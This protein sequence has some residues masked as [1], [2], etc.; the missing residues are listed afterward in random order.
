[1]PELL[2]ILAGYVPQVM[3]NHLI[4]HP[5]PLVT[6]SAERFPAAVLFADIS[7]FTALA[8]RLTQQ[9]SAGIEKLSN[10]LNTYFSQLIELIMAHG[11]EIF[12]FAGD[13]PIALWPVAQPRNHHLIRNRGDENLS[14]ATCRAVQCGLALQSIFN[15]YKVAEGL[16]LS[17]RVGIGAGE[18][19]MASVGGVR[20]RWE[21]LVAGEPITQMCHAERQAHPGEVVL[22]SEAWKLIQDQCSG[23]QLPEGGVLI[24][25]LREPLPLRPLSPINPPPGFEVILRSYIPAAILT[26]LDAGQTEWLAELRRITVLFFNVMG[27]DYTSPYILDRLQTVMQ[28]LQTVLYRYEGSVNQFLVDDK[29]TILVAALGLPPLAHEDDAVRGVQ[30][31]LGMQAELQQ[32]GL[33]SAAGIA[34]GRVFCGERGSLIRREYGM[35]GDVVNLAARL[36]QVVTEDLSIGQRILCDAATYQAARMRLAFKTLP[37]ITVKGK[38]EPIAVYSPY[39]QIKITPKSQTKMVGRITER[40]FLLERLRALREGHGSIVIIEGEAG[41]GKSR[42]IQ[43]L[44]QQAQELGIASLMGVGDAVEKSIPYHAWHPIFNQLFNLDHLTDDLET[45]RKQILAQLQVDPEWL[46]WAPLLNSI[47]SLDLPE[48]EITSQMSAQVRAENTRNLLLR[49]IEKAADR[50]PMMVI[51]E[52]AHWLDSASW[53]L[54]LSLGR[55][56]HHLL[57]IISTRPMMDP[58]LAEYH[59]FLATQPGRWGSKIHRL[60]LG[61]LLPEETV[62]M[63]T[64]RLG[65]TALPE[66]VAKLIQEKAEGH[67]LFSEELAYAL[68][69]AGLILISHG[70]CYIS[71][72]AGDFSTLNFSDTLQGL[73]IGR[74]DRLTAQQQL[75]LKV[76]SV[77]GRVF[78]SR[79]LQDIYPIESDKAQLVYYLDALEKLNIILPET[80]GSDLTYKFKH[81]MTQEVAYNLMLFSQRRGLHRAVARWYEGVYAQDLTPFYPLLAYHWSKAEEESKAIHYLEKAGEQA[82]RIGAYREALTFFSEALKQDIREDR[83]RDK[84]TVALSTQRPIAKSQLRWARWE[85]QM[86][87]ICLELGQLP[88]SRDHLER[89]LALLGRSVPATRRKLLLSLA[90]QVL[91][92]FWPG[93]PITQ[94]SDG[95]KIEKI[96][97]EE[98]R[99]ILLEAVRAYIQLGKVYYFSNE[100]SAVIHATLYTLHLASRLGPSPELAQSYANMCVGMGFI[101]LYS[102]A[103]VYLRRAQEAA[104]NL[105]ELPT[106]AYVLIITSVYRLGIG[107][108]AEAQEALNQAIEICD[109]LGNRQQWAESLILLEQIAYYQGVFARGEKLAVDLYTRACR[110]SNFLHQAWALGGQA[111]NKLRLGQIEEAITQLKAALDLY[112]DNIDRTSII[113]T[114]GLLA[115]GY[116]RQGEWQLARQAADMAVKVIANSSPASHY[117]LEGYAGVAEV[118]LTLWEVDKSKSKAQDPRSKIPESAK[119]AC[120]A[121]HRYAKIFPIGQPRAWLCQGLYNWLT[122]K[123]SRAYKAWQKS[124]SL[125]EQLHMPY[126]QGL[127]HYEIGRHLEAEARTR[128]THFLQ[129]YEIFDRLGAIDDRDRTRAALEAL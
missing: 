75:T 90:G 51:L 7:G 10:A 84:M 57:L 67:P 119:Q 115:L 13:A 48:N 18:V 73:V 34:T 128:Q 64:Q 45:R 19:L 36:M 126:E 12:K 66:S 71:P 8:E 23:Q 44:L 41:M 53:A 125:A 65:V 98:K 96:T 33:R 95:R 104:Q 50:T 97:P 86:G 80:P 87:E 106:L 91:R 129:A 105:N 118:Y 99:T 79:L 120:K 5:E 88:E 56:I 83:S 92:L 58:P 1:M 121:L 123:P 89:A 22:S 42:L 107:R 46:N 70:E 63:I 26:R 17:L 52:D 6:P 116:L 112:T 32:L 49:V 25:S 108:W 54:T 37:T 3:V 82:F 35:I 114:Y 4:S 111:E 93:R 55:R 124:L 59:Q 28:V 113:T 72:A 20:G 39:G 16:R 94:P 40:K 11:G 81:A 9:G 109:R 68:Q 78:S 30:A 74:I 77:I 27:L 61:P 102:L 47:L 117:L 14:L 76:A 85:R 29:G 43:D 127:A 110:S 101:P 60:Q 38:A 31:V 69:D 24:Q 15:E 62:E 2:Q 21:F 122:G 100:T 103:E